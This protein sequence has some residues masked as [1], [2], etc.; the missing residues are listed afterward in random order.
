MTPRQYIEEQERLVKEWHIPLFNKK[1]I[2]LLRGLKSMDSF[3]L[4][5]E[6]VPFIIR[7]VENPKYDV[8]L[9][10]GSV[11]LETHDCVHLLLGRGLMTKDEA[12]VIGY[13]MGST[14]KMSR[15]RKNLFMFFGVPRPPGLR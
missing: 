10:S 6:E 1:Q 15:W 8:G 7:L 3:K 2:S 11:S 13:T 14:K 4:K 12:F 9:F 5:P